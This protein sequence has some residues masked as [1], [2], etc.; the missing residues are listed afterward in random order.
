M[1][2]SPKPILVGERVRIYPRGKKK[3]YT[4]DF[5]GDEQIEEVGSNGEATNP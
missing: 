1:T 2:D 4:A 3:I 5:W